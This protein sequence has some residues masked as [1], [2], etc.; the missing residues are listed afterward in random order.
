MSLSTHHDL[1]SR[2]LSPVRWYSLLV[3]IVSLALTAARAQSV[4]WEASDSGD[5]SELVLVFRDCAPE[6]DP[7]LPKVDGV[8]F[9]LLGTS[10]QTNIV[11][12]S[13]SRSVL[14]SYRARSSRGGSIS[15]PSFT[16]QTTKGAIRVPAFTSGALRSAADVNITAKLETGTSTVWAGEIIPITY[17][18][19]VPRRSFSQ[20]GSYVEWTATPLVAEDWSKLELSE[21]LVNGESMLSL[22]CKTRGYAKAPG[23][24]TLNAATQLVNIQAGNVNFGLFQTPRIEQL[25][26]TTNRPSLV[27]RALPPGAPE[28]FSGAVGQFKLTSKIVPTTANVGEPVTWT[29]ELSGTGNW[30]DITGL[31]Q[32]AVSKDFNVVQ[33]QA[34]RTPAEGKLFDVTLSEDVVLVPTRAGNYTL[35]PLNFVYF[36]PASGTYQTI[37]TPAT[38]VSIAALP[39]P[40][41]SAAIQSSNGTETPKQSPETAPTPRVEVKPPASPTGIPRE[42]LMG[43]DSAI[44]P[45]GKRSLVTW[46]LAPFAILPVLWAWLAIRRAQQTDPIRARREAKARVAAAVGKLQSFQSTPL[47]PEA[48]KILLQWQHDTT[49]LWQISHAAPSSNALEDPAWAALWTEADRALY[50]V[51]GQL[52][53]DWAARAETALAS[54]N[55]PGFRAYTALLPRNLLPFVASLVVVAIASSLLAAEEAGAIDPASAYRKGEFAAA[56]KAWSS[57]IAK[58]PTDPIARYNL[59]LTLA[60]EDR[61]GEAA[62]HAAAAFVQ[63]PANSAMRWQVA[64]GAEKSGYIPAAVAGFFP[65]GPIQSLARL[66]APGAWQRGLIASAF[67][68]AGALSLLLFALYHPWSRLRVALGLV[69]LG[70]ATITGTASLAG[71]HAYGAMADKDAGIVWRAG[72]LR[73]IPTEADTTQKTTSLPA[74]SIGV[75]EKDLLGWVRLRFENGQTGWVR[76]EEVI[77]IWK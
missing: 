39:A 59:S 47:T 4:N 21:S 57:Q 69:T 31:P 37:S 33:P 1:S 30:P 6:A 18:L 61:W 8:T 49:R 62:A 25:S 43:S 23:P 7:Q 72:V 12:F 68:L 70:V 11:N 52:P 56:E 77:G 34:K 71:L 45:L 41:A 66:A 54:K 76:K 58:S 24:V 2:P 3:V 36:D 74:G 48:A 63:Q 51:N 42:P 67:L 14:L 9:S 53:A 20:P 73:S 44:V 29:V 55:V 15:I 17:A 28:G 19:E 32:R 22:T 5:P 10:E 75:A 64:L 65:A 13:M 46:T 27:V 40:S 26:V 38:R 16:V 50:G 35:G 60:Q